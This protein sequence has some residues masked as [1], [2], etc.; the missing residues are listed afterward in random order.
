MRAHWNNYSQDMD[1]LG[2]CC[3]GTGVTDLGLKNATQAPPFLLSLFIPEYHTA[4][5]H[6]FV[7]VL[8]AINSLGTQL[9]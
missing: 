1:Y 5:F 9:P 7:A 3:F 4:L 8:R 6:V 2:L